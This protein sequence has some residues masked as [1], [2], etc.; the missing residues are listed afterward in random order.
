MNE[1]E[2]LVS[3]RTGDKVFLCHHKSGLDIY[4]CEMPEFTTC[5]ALFGTRYGSVN[6]RFKTKEDTEF[7]EVPEGIAHYLEHKLFENEDC[8][9][10]EKYAKTGASANAYTS[11]DRTCYLFNCSDRYKDSLKIL[12][13]FVQDPYFTDENV[14]KEQGIIGQEIKMM[15]DTPTWKVFFNLLGCLYH[16]N[17]VKID[18]A[19]T[20]ESISKITKEL[21]Y[22]CYNTFYNLNNMILAIAGNVKT[23]EVLAIADECLKNCE[24]KGLETSF[25]DEPEKIVEKKIVYNM[26]V[27][28]PIFSIGFKISPKYDKERI[29]TAVYAETF[30]QIISNPSSKL[31]NELIKKGY[32]NST[33]SGECF[34]G[35]GYFALIFNGE[36]EH[37]DEV[38]ESICREIEEV[39]A[40]GVDKKQFEEVKKASYGDCIRQFNEVEYVATT[41][42]NSGLDKVSPFYESDLLSKMTIEDINNFAANEIDT[43]KSAVSIVMSQNGDEKNEL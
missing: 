27:G 43:E 9:A 39:K 36:S 2:T 12:L 1:I 16:N 35:N 33:F 37:A 3:S 22:K 32:I 40:K 41:M 25:P 42:I 10:F 7:T 24:D 30:L 13:D 18:I 15:D 4:I 11:F 21:L 38:Y 8:G 29:K 19:G 28:I 5:S 23:D 14:A 31:Y 34:S 6:T 17:P 20:V 26:E